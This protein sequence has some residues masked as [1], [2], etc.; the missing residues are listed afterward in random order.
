MVGASPIAG[1]AFGGGGI[2]GFEPASP[3]QS[4]LVYKK[5]NHY[6]E[7]EFTYSPLSDMGMG[8]MQGQP[9]Q[10]LGGQAPVPAE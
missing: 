6:N 5:K 1:Q 2:V 10:L 7:W 8:A 9:P 4:I 3:K